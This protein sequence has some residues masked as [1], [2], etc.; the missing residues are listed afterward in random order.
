MSR[1]R[2][3]LPP[4]PPHRNSLRALTQQVQEQRVV[5]E[6]V[7]QPLV[8]R[9]HGG[10]NVTGVGGEWTDLG[11]VPARLRILAQLPALGAGAF[12]AEV[13]YA[14]GAQID[15]V[16]VAEAVRGLVLAGTFHLRRHAI[17]AVHRRI[18][19]GG[20]FFLDHDEEHEWRVEGQTRSLLIFTPPPA[21]APE[22]AGCSVTPDP[23]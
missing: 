21:R 9:L 23:A 14:D 2:P 18:E 22:P 20:T 16:T 6:N 17:D 5:L 15:S 8:V 7:L 4:E 12:V 10:D 11:D 13:E 3:E 1:P 19:P